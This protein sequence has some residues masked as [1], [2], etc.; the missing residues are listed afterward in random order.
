M[1]GRRRPFFA[2][3]KTEQI[4]EQKYPNGCNPVLLGK[5]KMDHILF[6]ANTYGDRPS[7]TSTNLALN[8]VVVAFR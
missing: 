6:P 3:A 4:C 5:W 8:F 2:A 7:S 1:P